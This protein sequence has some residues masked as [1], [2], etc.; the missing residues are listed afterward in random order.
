[1]I[2][3]TVKQFVWWQ[4]K[5][6]LDEKKDKQLLIC[7]VL[8]L[9]DHEATDWLFKTYSKREIIEVADKI[10]SGQWNK[11][12]LAFWSLILGI[13]PKTRVEM[14]KESMNKK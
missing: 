10:P 11:K 13:H 7:Q 5:K 12:S 2:P 3:Q 1:M 4:D 8:N 6:K 14:I 9:G